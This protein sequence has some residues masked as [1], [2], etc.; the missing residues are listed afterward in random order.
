MNKKGI[1]ETKLNEQHHLMFACLQIILFSMVIT[2]QNDAIKL[3]HA[4]MENLY[5]QRGFHYH[6]HLQ[7]YLNRIY[8]LHGIQ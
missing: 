7:Y 8:Q 1:S 4:S 6:E 3:I 2:S 5:V